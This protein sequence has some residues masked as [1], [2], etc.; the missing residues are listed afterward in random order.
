[1][2]RLAALPEG[3]A[4]WMLQT[5]V[6]RD[7]NRVSDALSDAIAILEDALVLLN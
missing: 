5:Q 3:E 2:P 6:V 1:V 7:R 4:R